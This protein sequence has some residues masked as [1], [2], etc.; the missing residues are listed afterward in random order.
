MDLAAPPPRSCTAGLALTFDE[1]GMW[2]HLGG[3]YWQRASYDAVVTLAALLGLLAV[4]PALRHARARDWVLAAAI[5]ATLG[6]FAVLTAEHL[7]GLGAALDRI[8]R[9]GPR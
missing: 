7:H 1:F 3:S 2:L 9:D 5:M 6:L 8:E 4:A